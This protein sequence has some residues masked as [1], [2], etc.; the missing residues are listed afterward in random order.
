VTPNHRKLGAGTPHVA[1]CLGL[2][3]TS[4]KPGDY[5]SA[6]FELSMYN[7]SNGTYFGR[8]GSFC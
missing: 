2:S 6:V 5:M 4:F 7:H 1:L 3:G 8:K